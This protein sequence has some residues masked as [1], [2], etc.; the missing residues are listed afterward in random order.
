MKT[1]TASLAASALLLTAAG[2]NAQSGQVERSGSSQRT[3]SSSAT[4]AQTEA[5][6]RARDAWSARNLTPYRMQLQILAGPTSSQALSIMGGR[7]EFGLNIHHVNEEIGNIRI[8]DNSVTMPLGFV[9]APVDNLE[10]GLA[11]PIGFSPGNFGD[12]PLWATY[13]LT[14]G[15]F[16]IGIRGAL[17]I[18]TDTDFQAQ[19]GVPI[20][21][22]TGTMRFDTGAFFHFGFHDKVSTDIIVP[23][24]LGFQISHELY[25]GFQTGANIGLYDGA[26]A[27]TMPLYGFVGYTLHGGLGPIDLGLRFGFDQFVKAGDM[28]NTG[29]DANDFSF[30][31]GANIGLQF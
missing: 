17:Y 29:V 6:V 4:A 11:L 13:Q 1:L 22:R 21:I 31:V 26:T 14:N 5:A 7:Q 2:A 8:K 18:P 27:F 16:Q 30:A 19:V 28:P 20:L 24:R 23:L 3:A 9:F 15:P 25:A 12:M 10:V